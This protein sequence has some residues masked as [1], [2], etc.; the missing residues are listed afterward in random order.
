MD[1]ALVV[2]VLHHLDD[3]AAAACEVR[4]I[5]RPGGIMLIVDMKSHTREEYRTSM[6][7]RHLG[8]DDEDVRQWSDES[9]MPIE[10]LQ[11]LRPDAAGKGPGLFV[12]TLRRSV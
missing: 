11:V 5:L 7:H 10:R 1:V 9:G 12:A 4:R 2:L 6:G 8:F 3:P